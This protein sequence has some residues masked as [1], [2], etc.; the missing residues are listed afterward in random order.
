M[1][2]MIKWLIGGIVICTISIIGC[3]NMDD[4]ESEVKSVELLRTSQSWNEVDLPDY[5]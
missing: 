3:S 5:P 2:K 4:A 1:D